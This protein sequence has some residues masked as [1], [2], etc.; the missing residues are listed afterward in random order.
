MAYLLAYEEKKYHK[1]KF[2][3]DVLTNKRN[4]FQSYILFTDHIFVLQDMPQNMKHSA[5]GLLPFP[6]ILPEIFRIFVQTVLPYV[7]HY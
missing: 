7:T 5:L 4:H 2:F 1:Y 6:P 3:F